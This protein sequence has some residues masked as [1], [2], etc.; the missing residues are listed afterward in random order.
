LSYLFDFST[1]LVRVNINAIFIIISSTETKD[2]RKNYIVKLLSKSGSE[3]IHADLVEVLG[4]Q[5]VLID[6]IR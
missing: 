4:A 6:D 3:F 5:T 2:L 1:R